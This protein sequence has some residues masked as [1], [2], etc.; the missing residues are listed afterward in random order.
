[1]RLL[2]LLALG[3]LAGCV[4]PASDVDPAAVPDDAPAATLP[5]PETTVVKV[6]LPAA[7]PVGEPRESQAGAFPVPEGATH[8][9]VEARWS[10]LSPT[11]GFAVALFVDGEDVEAA[12]GT[13]EAA[14]VA[15]APAAGEH[16]VALMSTG[17]AFGM[18]G[19]IRAT[20]FFAP[21]PDGWSA[22][23]K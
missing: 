3:L 15:P 22:F 23:E 7:T 1:M 10:C 21:P 18:T 11:C 12:R 8:V 6:S 2:A 20:A 19:E 4:T 14:F 13:G 16:Q 5:A 9:L 17:P